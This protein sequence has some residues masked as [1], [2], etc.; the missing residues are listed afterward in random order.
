MARGVS[1]ALATLPGVLPPATAAGGTAP[2][3]RPALGFQFAAC[4]AALTGRCW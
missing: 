1:G 3:L 2:P 4:D